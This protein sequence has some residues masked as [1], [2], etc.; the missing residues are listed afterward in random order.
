MFLRGLP[1]TKKAWSVVAGTLAVFLLATLL[2]SV[3]G[4][5][6]ETR[7]IM[8]DLVAITTVI[9]PARVLS[10]RLESGL[11]MEYSALQGYAL[12]GDTTLLYRYR[13]I[14]NADARRLTSLEQLAPKL[15]PEAVVDAAA[16]R[17]RII[18]WQ[19]L[20]R[21][22]LEDHLARADFAAAARMQRLA[23][24]S[25]I[26]EI[27]RFPARL[28]V[29]AATRLEEVR[30]HEWS[31]LFVNAALVFVAL[32]AM[33]GVA[34]LTLRERHLA[35]ILQNRLEEE[36]ALR[37]ELERV[38]R[39]RQR[40]MRG[41][42]H[43]VKNPLGAADGY[44]ELLGHGIYGEVTSAQG[45]TIERIRRSIHGALSLI[46][47]LHEL[48][49]AETGNIVLR[50]QTVNLGELA[51]AIGEEYRGAANASGL[52]LDVEVAADLTTIETDPMRL[53]QIVGNLLSNAIKYT[54]SGSVNLRVRAGLSLSPGGGDDWAEFDVV[55]TGPGIPADK[56]DVIFEEFSRLGTSDKPGAGLGLAISKR[57]AEALGGCISVESEFGHGSTFTLR[58]P[59]RVSEDL[60]PALASAGH[61]SA[62]VDEPR[63]GLTV[64]S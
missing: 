41:F 61:P 59:I 47:D 62:A 64:L 17:R 12:S 63:E 27:D 42:S 43:D 35:A 20:N 16:V 28:S 51:C 53:R 57:L 25:I 60:D 18:K 44:A 52:S 36:S 32:A 31:G 3:L 33:L 34:A 11:A 14:A 19:D 56:R 46:E 24:D 1:V 22:L 30:G 29:E 26:D 2:G 10:W 58:I 45:A 21:V 13:T 40:L 38:M 7:G 39:S 4:P 48:A 54:K 8:R 15:G 55:D 9:E 23:R 5:A 50:R 37:R 6:L 49:R